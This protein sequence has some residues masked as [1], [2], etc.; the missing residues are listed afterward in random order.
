MR[1]RQYG[2]V[3]Q[4][5]KCVGESGAAAKGDGDALILS[6]ISVAD[7]APADVSA[8]ITGTRKRHKATSADLGLPLVLPLVLSA[9]QAKELESL[10]LEAKS[11]EN[12][13]P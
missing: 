5:L 1:Q 2:A 10:V 13:V 8:Q 3:R 9:S 12:K 11:S 6:C 4:L 7:Q